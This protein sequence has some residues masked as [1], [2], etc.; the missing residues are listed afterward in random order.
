MK[1]CE[2]IISDL[3][4]ILL[5]I[6]WFNGEDIDSGEEYKFLSVGFIFAQIRIYF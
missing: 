3:S 4:E 5:G 1:Y 2:I 6:E